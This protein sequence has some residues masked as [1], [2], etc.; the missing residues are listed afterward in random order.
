MKPKAQWTVVVGQPRLEHFSKNN[1]PIMSNVG[2]RICAITRE[3]NDKEGFIVCQTRQ[4]A[5]EVAKE[6]SIDNRF[7]HFHAKKLGV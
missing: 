2:R 3:A 4:K 1:P 7:W 5:R 6:M